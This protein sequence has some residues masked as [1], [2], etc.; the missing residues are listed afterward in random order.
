MKVE[1]GAPV[2]L[3]QEQP[4]VWHLPAPLKRLQLIDVSIDEGLERMVA[5]WPTLCL[6]TPGEVWVYEGFVRRRTLCRGCAFVNR[7]APHLV[8]SSEQEAIAH[9]EALRVELG[10]FEE[11]EA[12]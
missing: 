9:H 10:T 7:Q 8:P 12:A 1:I 2:V 6:E 4:E 5:T 11:L 3:L